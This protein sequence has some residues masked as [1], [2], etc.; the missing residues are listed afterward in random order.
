METAD[1]LWTVQEEGA[2]VPFQQ[3]LFLLALFGLGLPNALVAGFVQ[4]N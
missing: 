4:E 3:P 2:G 1:R